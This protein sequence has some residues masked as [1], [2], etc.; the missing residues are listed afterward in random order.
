MHKGA[1]KP[2]RGNQVVTPRFLSSLALSRI[3][4]MPRVGNGSAVLPGPQA[5]PV[6][7]LEQRSSKSCQF[8]VDARRNGGEHG[9]RD[10]PIPFEA[11]QG[12]RQHPLRDAAKGT[13]NLAEALRAATELAHDQHRPFVANARQ[14]LADGPAVLGHMQVT[15][16]QRCAFLWFPRGHL[17]SLG[18]ECEPKVGLLWQSSRSPSSSGA[19][20]ANPLIAAS[21]RRSPSS[22]WR[23][24]PLVSFRLMT[25]RF[26]IRISKASC[27]KASSGSSQR[28]RRPMACCS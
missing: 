21:R 5:Q 14:Y 15:R 13:A 10:Q 20:A 3:E 19:I 17:F 25:C 4:S 16:Y 24:F 6:H 1:T 7:R 11:P 26:I 2:R 9:A 8:V 28:L 18:I 12:Q 23:N 27:R 22:A